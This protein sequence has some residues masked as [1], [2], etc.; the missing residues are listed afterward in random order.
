M[1]KCYKLKQKES[2]APKKEKRIKFHIFSI[3]IPNFFLL[4]LIIFTLL[5]YVVQTNTKATKGFVFKDLDHQLEYLNEEN[6]KLE[7]EISKK[8]SLV[9]LQPKIGEMNLVKA[10]QVF[11]LDVTDTGLA[12][13]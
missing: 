5:F 10:N 9:D 2:F 6:K 8:Q 12:Q 3:G 4:S 1:I 11:F 7:L 13:K